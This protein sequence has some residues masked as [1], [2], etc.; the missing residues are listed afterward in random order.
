MNTMLLNLVSTNAGWL[1]RQAIKYSAVL[2]AVLTGW[3]VG[4]G[5]DATHAGVIAAAASSAVLGTVEVSLSWISRKYAVPELENVNTAIEAAKKAPLIV[6]GMM[7]LTNCAGIAAFVASPLGQASLVTAEALGKQLA[8]AAEEQVVG[9]I[10]T[11][12]AGQIAT[13]KA[14]GANADVAK[15]IV[16]QSELAGLQAVV[17]TAQQQYTGMTGHAFVLAKNPVPSVTP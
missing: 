14:Q 11:K 12:A 5:F 4:H 7:L 6:A 9:D 2:A 3:L 13:L 16:R 15:E 8:N 10:I 1:A 17:T